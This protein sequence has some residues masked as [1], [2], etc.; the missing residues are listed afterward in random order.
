MI[1]DESR[2]VNIACLTTRAPLKK[3]HSEDLTTPKKHTLGALRAP[4]GFY[5]YCALEP[6]ISV[7]EAI[8]VASYGSEGVFF[9]VAKS[10]E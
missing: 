10:S 1:L 2:K 5:E 8:C 9:G 3:Y 7:F 6:E 4:L